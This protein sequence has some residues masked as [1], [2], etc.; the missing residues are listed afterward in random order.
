ML[1]GRRFLLGFLVLAAGGL[2]AQTFFEHLTKVD[3]LPGDQ[4]LALHEDHH[5]FIWIGTESGL[6]RHEGVR[7]RT[8]HH[9]RKDANS[10]PNNVVWD[11][12]ADEHGRIWMGTDHG[13]GRYDARTGAFDRVFIT[14]AYNDPTS[15]NRIHRVV[16]DGH[17]IL[18]LSTEDGL[19]AITTNDVPAQV[20]LPGN[21]RELEQLTER[22]HIF[23][24]QKDSLR[25]GVWI[26]TDKGAVFFDAEARRFNTT[27]PDP[28]FACLNDS[29]VQ[30]VVP[31]EAGG[32]WYFKGA[33][34]GLVHVDVKGRKR[35]REVI[36]T[37][38]PDLVNPQFIRLDREGSLW[39]STWSHELRKL[40]PRTSN[41]QH[42]THDDAVPWSI[43]SSN[44]KCWLQDRSG[45]IWLGTYAGL[46]VMDPA[47]NG[48]QPY[49]VGDSTANTFV[50]A[51]L[52]ID[53]TRSIVGTRSGMYLLDRTRPVQVPIW[54]GGT[55]ENPEFIRYLNRLMCH[56]P[57]SGGW[58]LGTHH[59]LLSLDTATMELA[60]PAELLDM[61]PR[62]GRGTISFIQRDEHGI[63]WI[64]KSKNG[65]YRLDSVGSLAA[66]DS[67]AAAS[68]GTRAVLSCAVGPEGIWV[69]MNNG[70][71]LCLIRNDS[72]VLRALNEADSTGTSYGVVLSLARG[73]DGTLYIGTLM[74]GLAV[75]D[76]RTGTFTWYTRSDGLTGDRVERLLLDDQQGLWILTAD[77][78]CRFD[79]RT[80]TIDPLVLPASAR[81]LGSLSAMTFDVDGSL[82]CALGPVLVD[83]SIDR[84]Q[85]REGPPVILTGLRHGGTNSPGWP[86]DSI[87]ELEHDARSLSIEY[88][89]LNFF[90]DQATRFAYRVADMD[91]TWYHLG[92]ATRLDLNDL[93]PGKHRVE[94]RANSGGTAWTSRPLAL[95][96]RVLPPI[97]GT[98]WF[99]VVT[100]ALVALLVWA[101]A[102]AYVRGR[103]REQ[104]ERLEREQAVLSERMRIAGDMHDDM[105]AG[106]SALK[107]R[108]EMALRMEKDPAKREQLSNLA[109]TAGELIGS[110]RQII[111]TMNQDQAT[112]EDLVVYTSSYARSYCEQHGLMIEVTTG[113]TWPSLLL[114]TEQRRN[115]FLV[116][117]EALH[118]TVKHANARRVRLEMRFANGLE[119]LV[120]DDGIGVAS[121]SEV[122][123]GNGMRNMRKRVETLHG[124]FTVHA[125]GGTVVRFSVPLAATNQ[126]S[127]A[128][129]VER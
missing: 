53:R 78:I 112:V 110:M 69:G 30:D 33:T 70:H 103:L 18:L 85:E 43:I 1:V 73:D 44:T 19:H 47:H 82:L 24:L 27:S 128:T 123:E 126:G 26:D 10:L 37:D 48:L 14:R 114:S 11:I 64:G 49:L 71:G 98:W 90:S 57:V 120:A 84:P 58:L 77:G 32:T 129:S 93:P 41:W 5:G 55:S 89:A 28:A 119:V 12:T 80:H 23:G 67:I 72:I 31:D 104:R 17:G 8:W 22:L 94:V 54:Y 122:G 65:L 35:H 105:G 13:L 99:R 21:G 74:G 127:I 91:S 68:L 15:A 16:A 25:N 115:V 81:A 83:V 111:W 101:G 113:G 40:E 56:A 3:G 42:F 2:N 9:D 63:T 52:P 50:S 124:S 116:V 62:M 59:G 7:I 51:I 20:P 75:R 45:R 106:L 125:D 121:G 109:G 97:W 96:V 39:L 118:N 76:P 107:L 61:E 88:G 95:T 6:A 46:A 60:R 38:T 92:S 117:K 100:L 34:K 29:L 66:F 108:S 86:T 87:V 102:R 79:R 4:V 36:T